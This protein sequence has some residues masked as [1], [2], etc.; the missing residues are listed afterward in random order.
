[1]KYSFAVKYNG[2]F[3]PPNTEIPEESAEV[4]ESTEESA[5]VEEKPKT[6]RKRKQ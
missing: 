1:M 6:T 4:E 2:E 5:E 3:Y